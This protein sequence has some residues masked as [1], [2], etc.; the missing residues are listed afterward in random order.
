M[1]EPVQIASSTFWLALALARLVNGGRACGSMVKRLIENARQDKQWESDKRRAAALLARCDHTGA[2]L[3][4]RESRFDPY[5]W[6]ATEAMAMPISR[7][8]FEM[9]QA[10]G[11]AAWAKK[12]PFRLA[13]ED[14]LLR[15]PLNMGA[16]TKACIE[17]T[18]RDMDAWEERRS[19]K[20]AL[21][22]GLCLGATSHAKR[23]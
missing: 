11:A 23:L 1:R 5:A 19:I 4:W 16:A 3:L 9:A 14:M 15:S 17:Q 13:L 7:Y 18:L 21:G 20:A 22:L 2:C 10:C 8:E 6:V 12:A